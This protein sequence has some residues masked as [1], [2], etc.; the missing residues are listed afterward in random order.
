MTS[1]HF[2]LAAALA[3]P[4]PPASAE[5]LPN[6]NL[7]FEPFHPS[8]I[9]KIGERAGW[10]VH[11]LLGSAYTRYNYESRENNLKVLKA[12]AAGRPLDTA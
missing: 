9:Y 6:V 2:L 12:G 1:K 11:A 5:M 7:V 4:I 10:A 3:L 8:G